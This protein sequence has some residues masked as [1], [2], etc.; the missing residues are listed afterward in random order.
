MFI[1]GSQD[2]HLEK[3]ES[4]SADALI[5]DLE[6][7]VSEKDKETARCKVKSCL[8]HLT[9]KTNFVRVNALT[10]PHFL[11][12]VRKVVCSEL[13]GIV[14]PKVNQKEDIGIADYL[15]GQFEMRY[16]LPKAFTKIVPIIESASGLYR[17]HEIATASER[18]SCLAF[19]A[20]D[21]KLDVTIDSQGSELELLYARSKLVTAS[22]AAGKDAPIDSVYTDFGDEKGL[23]ESAKMGKK[24]GFQGKLL[25][26]P[27]QINTVNSVYSPTEEQIKEAKRILEVYETS[28]NHED[29]AIQIDGKMVDRPVVE[30]ARKLLSLVEV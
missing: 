24:L 11:E 16:H 22:K 1:P 10:T 4:L 2:K 23:E 20:E 17:A 26:H 9:E 7:A 14:L 18:I 13:A 27:K 12:D 5:F 8:S 3:A 28:F 6:D 21:Y 29:G 19:G 30:Q 15:L 25:I